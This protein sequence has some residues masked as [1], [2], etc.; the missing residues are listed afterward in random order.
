MR[1]IASAT[2]LA[3]LLVPAGQKTSTVLL[4]SNE[5]VLLLSSTR[6]KCPIWLEWFCGK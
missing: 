4:E 5:G 3:M 1:F 2:I 6:G